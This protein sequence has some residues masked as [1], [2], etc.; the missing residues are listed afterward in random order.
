ME[1]KNCTPVLFVKDVKA[2]RKFYEEILELKVDYDFGGLNVVF[3][4]GF[5]LWQIMDDNIIPRIL[6]KENIVDSRLISRFELCFETENIDGIYRKLKENGTE[7]LHEI[8]V[9]LWGQR[10][11]RFYDP[12]GH[13]VEVGEAMAVFLH[14]VYEEENFDIE[15]TSKRTFTSVEL[16]KSF[17]NLK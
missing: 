2:T 14:R 15:A 5:A 13:L 8:N 4:E 11:I 9:E 1:L 17:L 16:L 3:N 7:F 6:G 12:D 10:T